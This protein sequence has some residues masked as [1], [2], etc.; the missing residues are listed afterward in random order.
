M[1]MSH[2]IHWK[3]HGKI[4]ELYIWFEMVVVQV[5]RWCIHAAPLYVTFHVKLVAALY[6]AKIF[7][8]IHPTYKSSVHQ[9]T[10][11][12]IYQVLVD[13]II[14]WVSETRLIWNSSLCAHGLP[15]LRSTER[16]LPA[17]PLCVY[18]TFS[19]TW[20]S[21]VSLM[22]QSRR[23]P[24]SVFFCLSPC[25]TW[26]LYEVSHT[27]SS[28]YRQDDIFKSE[29]W[30]RTQWL[31]RMVA[32]S[33]YRKMHNKLE[34]CRALCHFVCSAWHRL[35]AVFC[36]VLWFCTSPE[37]HQLYPVW[38]VARGICLWIVLLSDVVVLLSLDE[39]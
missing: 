18:G 14:I 15:K 6:A 17:S 35:S 29:N 27:C 10:C 9:L 30:P 20:I 33:I 13:K 32:T 38:G 5:E 2:A 8:L 36:N 26:M 3:W 23:A 12:Q 25:S 11:N 16:L 21:S 39:A 28:A 1:Y 34:P 31:V 4:V 19:L 37:L 24:A 22:N 7:L